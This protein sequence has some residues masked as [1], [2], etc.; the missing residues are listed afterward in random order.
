MLIIAK[1]EIWVQTTDGKKQLK[2][3]ELAEVSLSNCK[4]LKTCYNKFFEFLPC[5]IYAKEE[6]NYNRVNYPKWEV[7][8]LT[9]TQ[10]SAFKSACNMV[11]SMKA[12]IVFI[13]TEVQYKEYEEQINKLIWIEMAE[14]AEVDEYIETEPEIENEAKIPDETEGSLTVDDDLESEVIDEVE[15]EVEDLS[16]TS[17]VEPKPEV[18]EPKKEVKSNKSKKNKKS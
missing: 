10:Y 12:Q 18:E 6:T 13:E 2:V 3:W 1:K 8:E 14:M 11:K 7:K 15:T 5:M 4:N 17:E 16:E 9:A